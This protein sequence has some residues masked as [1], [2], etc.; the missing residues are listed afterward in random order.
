MF[1]YF[2]LTD[3]I[4]SYLLMSQ[5]PIPFKYTSTT[6]MIHIQEIYKLFFINL[7]EM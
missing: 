3:K 7:C 2:Y 4:S 5:L 6:E 1:K